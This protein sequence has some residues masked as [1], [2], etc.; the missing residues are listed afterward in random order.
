M[1][2][3][4]VKI[5]VHSETL[6]KA[7]E[8]RLDSLEDKI[9]SDEVKYRAADIYKDC[10]APLVP[11]DEGNLRE[12]GHVGEQKYNGDYPVVYDV[13]YAKAQYEGSNGKGK[14]PASMWK[15]H[16][17]NTYDHWNH[18][19]SRSDRQAFYDLVAEEIME[20]INNG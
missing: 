2:S 20:K 13:K 10:I 15:R 16:T 18:H 19:M 1:A 14:R 17:P 8:K 7:L 5:R 6:A 12:S 11:K 4:D 3:F 9:L